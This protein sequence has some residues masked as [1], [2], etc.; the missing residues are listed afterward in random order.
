[1]A[2]LVFTV[3]AYGVKSLLASFTGHTQSNTAE[4][5]SVVDLSSVNAASSALPSSL[6]RELLQLF[7]LSILAAY[8]VYFWRKGQTLAMKTWGLEL[9]TLEGYRLSTQQAL[10]RLALSWIWFWPPLVLLIPFEVSWLERSGFAML[11]VSVWAVLSLFHPRKQ[12]WHDD[13]A[14]TQL[15][16]TPERSDRSKD[17]V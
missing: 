3:M 13:W 11:W 17:L 7:I 14:R 8:F 1:M 4:P 16:L 6:E 5:A 10:Q 9:T 12:F 2:S 15:V